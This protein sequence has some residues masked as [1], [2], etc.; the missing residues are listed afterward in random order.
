M[1]YFFDTEFIEDGKTI[2]LL[3]IGIIDE[4]GREF[5]QCNQDAKLDK[6]SDWVIFNVYPSLGVQ[7]YGSNWYWKEEKNTIIATKIEIRD[8]LIHFIADDTPEFWAY[9]AAYDWIVLCQLFGSMRD[10]P[11]EWPQYC[12][13]IKQLSYSLENPELPKNQSRHN[14]LEDARWVRYIFYFLQ[15]ISNER[16]ICH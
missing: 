15:Q 11:K 4:N 5:Y 6:A 16:L 12:L 8:R 10:L 3:S 7:N 9:Y 13:D 2:D 1:K 14:A